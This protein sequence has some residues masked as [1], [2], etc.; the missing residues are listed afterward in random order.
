MGIMSLIKNLTFKTYSYVRFNVIVKPS[1]IIYLLNNR[2]KICVHDS[3]F[4]DAKQKSFSRILL[5]Q[6]G[7]VV[8]FGDINK[9]YFPYGFDVKDYDD[10]KGY[11]HYTPF[12]RLRDKLNS[13]NPSALILL[14][15]KFYF[16]MFTQYLGID[17]P[18]NVGVMDRNQTFDINLKRFV[19]TSEFLINLNG[20]F[21]VKLIDGECGDGIYRIKVK[22][23]S[24]LVNDKPCVPS[25]FLEGLQTGSFLVQNS[26]SQNKEMKRL[27]PTSVNTIRLVTIRDRKS[28]TIKVFPSIL[29]IG[30]GSSFVDNTSQGGLA[31]GVNLEDGSL[32]E[33]G[34]YK[35]EFG[36]KTSVHPDS[37]IKFSNFRIPFFDI[38]KDQAILLHSML[39][40]IHSIG[41]DIAIGE[42]GPIFIEGNDNW[43]INGPQICNGPLK[44]KFVS[45]I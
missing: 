19:P 24:V 6:I 14:K 5:D 34:F 28:N 7:E 32:K 45:H 3:Y 29:R 37:H 9:F 15:D 43:E 36:T 33:F 31:V 13:S 42:E 4:P 10:I 41:W 18:A 22:E 21:F 27:H 35:P 16:G 1:R 40:S 38:A 25:K 8:K 39:P 2:K 20:D 26:I 44:D 30:T 12:M 11:Y 17:S 23:G